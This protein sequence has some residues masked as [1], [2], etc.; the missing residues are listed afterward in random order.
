MDIGN[1]MGAPVSSEQEAFGQKAEGHG[2]LMA[3]ILMG[4]GRV[5][6]KIDMMMAEDKEEDESES[7]EPLVDC[8]YRIG[9]TEPM[10]IQQKPEA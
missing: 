4:L 6:A 3:Q 10:D 2:A 8:N 5:E 1:L 9:D 7:E